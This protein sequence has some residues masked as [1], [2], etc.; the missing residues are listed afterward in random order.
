MKVPAQSQDAAS[1]LAER[2]RPQ[3]YL[4]FEC[5]ALLVARKEGHLCWRQTNSRWCEIVVINSENSYDEL[6]S[7][8]FLVGSAH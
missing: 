5:Y 7:H 1:R 3:R 8:C 6:R 2:Q 4:A